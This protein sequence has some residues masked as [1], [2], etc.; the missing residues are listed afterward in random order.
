MFV[1]DQNFFYGPAPYPKSVRGE[2]GGGGSSQPRR[3]LFGSVVQC[4]HHAHVTPRL[5]PSPSLSHQASSYQ[6]A[7]AADCT[8]TVPAAL[9]QTS[10]TD[11]AIP[12]VFVAIL[13][14]G[15][16]LIG[17]G[18]IGVPYLPPVIYTNAY[19]TFF[20]GRPGPW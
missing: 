7:L 19:L 12:T 6:Y 14:K 3:G 15:A 4:G 16:T 17:T 20:V 9:W 13:A 1:A 8:F 11:P 2:R 18:P 10:P 5:L